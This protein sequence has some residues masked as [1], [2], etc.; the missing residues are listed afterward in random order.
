[1]SVAHNTN[2]QANNRAKLAGEHIRDNAEKAQDAM[3]SGLNSASENT[4]RFTDQV[5]QAYGITGEGREELTRQGAQ[6][7]EIMTQAST[8]LTRGVQDLSREWFSLTQ[9]RLQ[10]NV[11]DFAVLARCQSLPDFMA[12]QSTIMRHNL[13]QTIEGTRRIGEVATRVANE[14][15]QTLKAETKKAS[16]AA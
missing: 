7:L 4:Q 9:E 6:S 1:M 15:G 3:R 14:A 2:N 8:M 5:T 10:K 12:A 11:E 13:E 16:S